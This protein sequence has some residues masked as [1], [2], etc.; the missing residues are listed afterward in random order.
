MKLLKYAGFYSLIVFLII[1]LYPTGNIAAIDAE[2][3]VD[4]STSA[5]NGRLFEVSDLKP[6][7]WAKR[8]ITVE[9]KGNRDFE[10]TM[11]AQFESGDEMFYQAL[12]F[13]LEHAGVALFDGKL[14]EFTGLGKRHLP[15]SDTEDFT[16]TIDFPYEYGNEYQGLTTVVLFI[17]NAEAKPDRPPP[18]CEERGDC[19]EP[20]KPPTCEERGDC[21]EPPKPPTCEERGDCPEPPKPPT[22]EERGDCSEK[23]GCEE[24]ENCTEQDKQCT[25]EGCSDSSACE[26][27]EDCCEE[28]EE[29]CVGWV[30]PDQDLGIP[31]D[32]VPDLVSPVGAD[33]SNDK[34]E[35]GSEPRGGKLPK[36]SVPWYNLLVLA[37][38]GL[39]G[40]GA[41]MW[42]VRHRNN[43]PSDE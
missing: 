22:C 43:S 19:P 42:M 9:N 1:S 17:F 20:P 34:G 2:P 13:K 16:L 12:S 26:Q 30:D 14:S 21:P 38:I 28:G 40:S 5:P 39:A 37:L 41:M 25:G 36:T 7:D 3:K 8:D 31:D 6:G 27:D 10:Y 33:S 32:G 23:P 4:I 35:D 11:T 15:V 18:T 29:N 24:Q